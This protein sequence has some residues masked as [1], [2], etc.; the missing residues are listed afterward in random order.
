[1]II[2]L[3][4][5]LSDMGYCKRSEAGVLIRSGRLT[6]N[7][8]KPESKADTENDII[9]L[10]GERIFY[11]EFVY[12]MMNKPPGVVSSTEDPRERT[13]MDLLPERYAKRKLFPMGR[14]DKD[15]V[16]LL[17]L[18]DDGVL[19][20]NL[21]SPKKHVTKCYYAE[22]D[23]FLTAEDIEKFRNGIDIGGYVCKPAR[24]EILEAGEI[25]KCHVEITEGKFH[26]VKRMMESVGKTVAFLKRVEFGGLK[27]DEGL[28]LSEY[29]E[30]Y[31][32]ELAI[33]R[34]K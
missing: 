22:T 30:L 34:R 25:S 29:R 4:K 26:Q 24:L 5:L 3:D 6:V 10:D 11:K 15:T 1:M 16:G 8:K 27:L 28:E 12:I 14:L 2:R 13:V 18:T 32:H 20:H 31:E 33:L 7:G 17:I 23:G 21:L 9:E 19:A